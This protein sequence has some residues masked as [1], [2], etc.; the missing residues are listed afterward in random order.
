ME[1]KERLI[2]II[3]N[4]VGGCARNWAEVIAD[5]LISNG[6]IVL[7]CK[8]GDTVYQI[9][10]VWYLDSREPY[11][12]HY[13]K[14]VLEF[15]VRSVSISCNSKSVWTKKIRTCEIKNGKIIDHQHNIEFDEIGKTVFLTREEAERE[16]ERRKQ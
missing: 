6:V 1:Q 8:V 2:E 12:Y 4:S 3:Q 16:L 7:P 13:E 5:G 10:D 15:V 9:D 11:T 14:E